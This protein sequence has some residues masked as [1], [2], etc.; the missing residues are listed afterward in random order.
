MALSLIAEQKSIKDL[1][2]NDDIYVIP[3][4][5]RPYAWD[6][7]TCYQ[8][9]CDITEA[10]YKKEDYFLGNLVLAKSEIDKDLLQVVDGQQRLITIWLWIKVLS[11]LL[12]EG[13]KFD[14]MLSV[15]G[16]DSDEILTKIKLDTLGLSNNS[17]VN[18]VFELTETDIDPKICKLAMNNSALRINRMVNDALL[19]NFYFIWGWISQFFSRLSVDAQKDFANYFIKNV[20]L[21]PIELQGKTM[22]EAN[23]KALVIFETINNRGLD[24]SDAD[25]FKARL[26]EKAKSI[27]ME[28][29][30]IQQW[31]N[32][33]DMCSTAGVAIVD[34][35]RYYYHII[36]GKMRIVNAE[37]NLRD[38][39]MN[40]QNSP[41]K[42]NGY[43]DILN[44]LNK[45]VRILLKINSLSF[46]Q[47]ETSKWLQVLG[48]YSNRYP[49][50]AIV[51]YL[52]KREAYDSSFNLF[53]KNMIRFS[54]SIGSTTTIKFA[55]YPIIAAIMNDEDFSK[56]LIIERRITEEDISNSSSLLRKGLVLLDYYINSGRPL[57]D[58]KIINILANKPSDVIMENISDNTLRALSGLL[59]NYEVFQEEGDRLPRQYNYRTPDLA[60]YIL[61][62][63]KSMAERIVN[64]LNREEC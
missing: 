38:F 2:R 7:D 13:N 48:L 22:E 33:T 55:I 1:F 37:S 58:I 11:I 59:G 42:Q 16:L 39:F 24:L 64:F 30:F 54:Y 35:F 27:S 17:S 19:R 14:T 23:M 40:F 10:Y 31:Q 21:L 43:E 12:P 32:L 20:Y 46:S 9:Y 26:Y 15:I 18:N 61:D 36:R 5:Q 63:D 6:Y 51:A 44:N 52:Y 34:L 60:Y 4:Y 28:D 53:L 8:M 3:P 49:Q 25:I 62:R 56:F 41:L 50:Y 57:N 47:C 45:I 29:D